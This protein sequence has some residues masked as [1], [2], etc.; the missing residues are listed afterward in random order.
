LTEKTL[1][2]AT[3]FLLCSLLVGCTIEAA[4]AIGG[5]TVDITPEELAAPADMPVPPSTPQKPDATCSNG[6]KVYVFAVV[7]GDTVS[8]TTKHTSG[9]EAGKF[10]RVRLLDVNTPETHN[11]AGALLQNP[12][13]YGAE[14]SAYTKALVAGQPICLTFDPAAERQSGSQDVYG[15]WLAYAWFG[16]RFERFL[17]AELLWR[18][19]ARSL[20][21]TKKTAYERYLLSLESEAKVKA[22]GL[23]GSCR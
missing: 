6:R 3:R 22:S 23:W 11:D 17:N 5:A 9:P 2:R 19:L 21:I 20:I 13:C 16:D 10:E 12:D 1:R 7:D 8:L 14:A 18:G 4:P 15:R